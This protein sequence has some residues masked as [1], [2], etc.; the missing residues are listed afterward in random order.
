MITGYV[1]IC[2]TKIYKRNRIIELPAIEQ[3][4]SLIKCVFEFTVE[5][6]N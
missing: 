4:D 6:V 5:S 2:S 3:L 1:I